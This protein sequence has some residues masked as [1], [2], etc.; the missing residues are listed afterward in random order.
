MNVTVRQGFLA[1]NTT[2][3]FTMNTTVFTVNKLYTHSH[4]W[5]HEPRRTS[6]MDQDAA[7]ADA[8]RP[9]SRAERE[10][11]RRGDRTQHERRD[12]SGLVSRYYSIVAPG[13]FVWR[14]T[15]KI[16]CLWRVTEVSRLRAHQQN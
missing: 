10:P 13:D 8:P 9:A 7:T 2:E 5:T 6:N 15:M 16:T 14:I 3:V 12:A 4:T 1:M 11:E